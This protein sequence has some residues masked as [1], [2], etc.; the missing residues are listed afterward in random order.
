MKIAIIGTRGVPGRYGGFETLAEQL[1]VRLS[2]R[3]HQV[4]VYC[5]R[6]F[7]SPTDDFDPRARR[8]IL[9]GLRSKHF[10]TVFHTLLSVL[11]VI[12]TDAEVALICN[13]ANSPFAW[14]PRLFGIATVLNV[15]GLD[16]KRRKW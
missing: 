10:D 4:S 15:D 11:H 2:D 5:R 16:R 7:T 3:G 8:I 14:I 13:V 12:G 9:P 1:A 6:A